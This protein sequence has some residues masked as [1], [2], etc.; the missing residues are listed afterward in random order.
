M[1][2]KINENFV[3]YRN[4]YHGIKTQRK[5]EVKIHEVLASV[6]VCKCPTSHTIASTPGEENLGVD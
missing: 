4:K 3:S 1:Q 2:D 6:A 5:M